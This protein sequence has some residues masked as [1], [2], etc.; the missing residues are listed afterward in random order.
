[1]SERY[2]FRF[3]YIMNLKLLAYIMLGVIVMDKIILEKA[4]HFSTN[5]EQLYDVSVK[6]SIDYKLLDDGCS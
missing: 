3:F 6:D 1:M 2:F 4:I 5:V